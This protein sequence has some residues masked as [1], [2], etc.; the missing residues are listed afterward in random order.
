MNAYNE[1]EHKK[2]HSLLTA[3]VYMLPESMKYRNCI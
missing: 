2:V 3:Y 1:H